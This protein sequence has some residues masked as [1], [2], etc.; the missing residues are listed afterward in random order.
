MTVTIGLARLPHVVT[1]AE[2][3]VRACLQ[4]GARIDRYAAA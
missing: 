3:C 4:L 1:K 2:R